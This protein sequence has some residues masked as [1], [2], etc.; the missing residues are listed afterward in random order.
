MQ[1]ILLTHFSF[2]GIYTSKMDGKKLSA[3]HLQMWHFQ[4][5]GQAGEEMLQIIV[6]IEK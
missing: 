3:P 2:I 1:C 6:V 4:S 5:G